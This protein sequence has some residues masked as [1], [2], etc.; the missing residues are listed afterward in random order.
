VAGAGAASFYGEACAQFFFYLLTR[1]ACFLTCFGCFD[2]VSKHQNYQKTLKN[3]VVVSR[4]K[5]RM[6]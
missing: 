6:N 1:N 4:N 5:Q 2:K 3:M